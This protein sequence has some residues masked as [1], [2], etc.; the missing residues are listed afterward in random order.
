MFFF[1]SKHGAAWP[2]RH[3]AGGTCCK[4]APAAASEKADSFTSVFH[5]SLLTDLVAVLSIT[6]CSSSFVL[7]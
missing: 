4:E 5:H 6:G 1:L 7:L 3:I 2:V